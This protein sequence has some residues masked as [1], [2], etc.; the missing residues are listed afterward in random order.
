MAPHRFLP[1]EQARPGPS[2]VAFPNLAANS[3]F[4]TGFS[5]REGFVSVW[6]QI[7]TCTDRVA[8]AVLSKHL[9][10]SSVLE[11]ERDMSQHLLGSTELSYWWVLTRRWSLPW[12]QAL[13]SHG[14]NLLPPHEVFLSLGRIPLLITEWIRRTKM[15]S[16]ERRLRTRGAFWG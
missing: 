9:A 3:C 15:Y 11:Q 1:P 6:I 14:R 13:G 16:F 2:P 7:P 8:S 4:E 10:R 5:K 12:L